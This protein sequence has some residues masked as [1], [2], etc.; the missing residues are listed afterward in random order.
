V[1]LAT[2]I[3]VS[4]TYFRVMKELAMP[5]AT[6]LSLAMFLFMVSVVPGQASPIRWITFDSGKPALKDLTPIGNAYSQ[7][8][9]TFSSNALSLSSSLSGGAGN[10][11]GNPTGK[12]I[13]T[14]TSG[15]SV[16]MND[17]GGFSNGFSFYYTSVSNPATVTVWSGAN[18]TGTVLASI[19]LA[20]TNIGGCG[21]GTLF[22]KWVPVGLSFSGT[23]T[24][25]TFSGTAG[26]IGFDSLRLGSNIPTP[27]PE[28]SSILLLGTGLIGLSW[29]GR[30]AKLR[31]SAR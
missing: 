19:T 31:R 5:R 15:S 29:F 4:P 14:F 28:P 22:C 30:Q 20:P 10:F 25:V 13:M 8:G 6:V 17:T 21:T 23:A 11:T 12:N 7:M 9:I 24:S 2:L 3:S 16:T 27:S 1:P 18:G 26:L